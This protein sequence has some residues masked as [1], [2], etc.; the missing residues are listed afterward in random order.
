VGLLSGAA[1]RLEAAAKK[2][3]SGSGRGPVI[4]L[5]VAVAAFV[6]LA[7]L[8][9][10]RRTPPATRAYVALREI[11]ARREGKLADSVPPAEVARRLAKVMPGSKADGERIV[12]VYAASAF[13]GRE[14]DPAA[15]RDIEESVKRLRKLA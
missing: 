7:A 9:R 1:S 4:G 11:L 8:A 15:V 10:R 13:G 3:A 5:L 12:K 14:P 6:L 2:I